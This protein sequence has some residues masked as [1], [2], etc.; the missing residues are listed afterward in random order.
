MRKQVVAASLL[1]CLVVGLVF[2]GEKHA[3]VAKKEDDA[4]KPAKGETIVYSARSTPVRELASTLA[5]FFQ[6]SGVRAVADPISNLLIIRV[7]AKSRDE[8]LGL[9]EKLDQPHR[10]IT[11]HAQLLRARGKKLDEI[12]TKSFSGPSDEVHKRIRDLER[13]GRLYVA[14]R[15]ELTAV[16]NQKVMLQVGERVAVVTGTTTSRTGTP[17]K[18]YREENVGTLISVQARTA[19]GG[20]ITMDV[21]FNKSEVVDAE[22]TSDDKAGFVPSDTS[23]LTQQTTLQIQDGH[24]VL[25]S[26]LSSHSDDETEEV[27]LVVGAKTVDAGEA[28][29]KPVVFRAFSQ[30]K[31]SPTARSFSSSS[32]GRRLSG[33]PGP[34]TS[35]DHRARYVS[36]L[37][38]EKYDANNDEVLTGGEWK[39]SRFINSDADVNNDGKLTLDELTDWFAKRGW[40]PLMRSPA[41]GSK[42]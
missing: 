11:V 16:E 21:D 13:T 20:G 25:V 7:E 40:S 23:T 4:A 41:A 12:D 31:P 32:T 1:V 22:P 27:Y 8:V 9:L 28:A 17:I 37:M 14:N 19:Q 26:S 35:S 18:S 33:L 29:G 15:M 3:S 30:R 2:A 34:G 10:S 36:R 6:D 39:N 42:E 24:C 38:L 5:E